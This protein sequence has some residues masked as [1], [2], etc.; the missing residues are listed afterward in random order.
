M[1]EAGKYVYL[2]DLQTI[3]C[4]TPPSPVALPP[5]LSSINTPLSVQAWQQQLQGHPD[6]AFYQYLLNG[7]RQG[8]RIGYDYAHHTCRAS[9]RNM[10]SAL[11]NPTVVDEY[12]AKEK[13]LGRVVGPI[14]PG[15]V[16]LQINRFGVIP[17]SSQP[18]K[19][20]LIVDLSHPAG[21][22]INDGIEPELCTLSY[23]SVDDAVATILRFGRGTILAKLDL[24]SAYR[25]LPIHPDDRMLL[26]MEWKGNWYV[27]TALPFGLRSAPKIFTAMAD[28]LLWIMAAN[29]VQS[30]LHYLDDYIFFGHPGSSECEE[31]LRTAL[32][33]CQLLG[34]PV[35]V[36][37]LEGPATIIVFLG[38]ELD[39]VA[40]EMRLPGDKLQRLRSIIRAWQEKK[41]CKKRDLLSLIGH[42]Q[43]ACKVVRYG[44]SFLRRMINL[45]MQVKELH[46]HIRLNAS[47]R[48]DLLWWAT[49]LPVWNGVSMMSAP[50]RTRYDAL[51]VSD[52]SGNW[53][54]GAYT[55]AGEWFQFQWPTAWGSV[56][57]TIKELLPIVFSCALWGA[58]WKGKTVKCQCDN[59]AVVAIINSGKS[60]D[61]RA[62]HL[63]RCL[64]FYLAQFSV[65]IYAEHIPGITNIAADA[66]SRDNLPLFRQQVRHATQ[67]PTPIPQEL[68]LALVVHQPDWTSQKWR[69]WFDSTLRKV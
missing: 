64:T 21:Y 28:G 3:N 35:S 46:H 48:S 58:R 57:I 6:K 51:L 41:S 9:S 23:A 56:H 14:T 53:G 50:S 30:A 44:R 25:I 42:L 52:A 34:V 39:T 2:S 63:M 11:E 1:L 49:F 15:S 29:G 19:W 31:F 10:S 55:T 66:L 24:E 16:Q 22:S 7:F 65:N 54:C 40:L 60:K 47:F 20:R 32:S 62:M 59:A 69:N 43:H 38:I 27:D 33:L 68:I 18:G 45:S 17:K 61:D 26:G 5:H 4:R 12:L 36:K 13:E 67:S 37:K 8:F